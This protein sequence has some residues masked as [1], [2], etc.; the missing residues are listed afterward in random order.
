MKERKTGGCLPV[1][2][3]NLLTSIRSMSAQHREHNL[4]VTR[5]RVKLSAGRTFQTLRI[6]LL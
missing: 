6:S 5:T 2:I 1:L 3:W 4:G